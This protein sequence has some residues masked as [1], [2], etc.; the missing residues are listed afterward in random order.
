MQPGE[1]ADGIFRTKNIG[2]I[3]VMIVLNKLWQKN[4]KN[5]H[6]GLFMRFPLIISPTLGLMTRKPV[7]QR[8]RRPAR[9]LRILISAIVIR[10]L[11]S[12]IS[13]LATSE[14]SIF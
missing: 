8:M 14:I 6:L 2:R 9:H 5:G 12:I 3:I 4:T 10:L 13:R 11:Q 7:E 1:E